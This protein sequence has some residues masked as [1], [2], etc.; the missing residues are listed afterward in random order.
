MALAERERLATE[1]EQAEKA[2]DAAAE[3]RERT[4]AAREADVAMALGRA[5]IARHEADVARAA[6]EAAQQA[7]RRNVEDSAADRAAAK[8]DLDAADAYRTRA[9]A[10]RDA[11]ITERNRIDARRKLE[12]AQLEL[13]ARG[14]DD[15]AGLELRPM[16]ESFSMRKAAMR[17]D[18]RVAY[19]TGWSA[20]IMNL[21]RRLADALEQVRGYA[22][23]LLQREQELND[24]DAALAV[25][26]QDADR[27]R[28][29]RASEHSAAL[30]DLDRRARELDTR[31]E[32][33]SVRAAAADARLADAAARE[34]DAERELVRHN[35]WSLAVDAIIDHPDWIDV[36]G[37][38]I[39]LDRHAAATID[40]AL[41]A[42]LQETPPTWAMNVILARLDVADRH[43]VAE[44]H[45][46]DA[47]RSRQQLTELV[48]RAGRVLTPDQQDMASEVQ[49]TVKR[50]A[51]AVQ[52]W[53]AARGAGR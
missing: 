21:A 41:V 7:A 9:A 14:A 40:P 26:E 28:R 23:R 38:T 43:S 39:R 34:A 19:E 25:R 49:A 4:I 29:A 20:P 12:E 6:M 50:S 11:S 10:D 2:R 1:R 42:T 8:K 22:R 18:E 46:A 15:A 30:V 17:P 27:D 33:A 32:A 44:E 53:N 36:T 5:E 51:A 24:R 35:R 48:S 31:E 52:A 13:L 45:E 16:G 47:A 3:E 37:N